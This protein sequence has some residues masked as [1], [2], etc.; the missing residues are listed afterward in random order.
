[1]LN[2]LQFI[3]W[4]ILWG[5]PLV[6]LLL[7]VG[8]FFTFK[9]NFF[10]I[11]Y[12]RHIIKEVFN[13]FFKKQNS[14]S[15]INGVISP[16][17][18]LSIA[19][20]ATVGVGNIGGVAAAI[21]IGGPGAV[22]WLWVGGIFG[23]I[24]KMVEI[25]LAVHYRTKEKNGLAYGGPTYYMKKG[26]GQEKK[27]KYTAHILSFIF[28]SS[29]LVSFFITMQN[30]TVSE[31]LSST[32]KLDMITVSCI[33]TILLYSII[34]GG[35]RS[36]GKIAAMLVPVM[37]VFYITGGL[38]IIIKNINLLP[39]AIELIISGAFTGTAAIG[40]FGGAI[41]AQVIKIG[42]SR[43]VFSNEAGWGSSSMIHASAKTDHPIRQGMLGIFEV[44]IDTIIICSIT[45]LAIIITGEWSSG[46]SGA[47]LTLNA[48]EHGFGTSGRYIMAIGILFF[49]LTTS[50]GLFVQFEVLLRYVLGE[51]NKLKNKIL[52]IYKWIYPIPGILLVVIAVTWKM[53]GSYVWLF[54]DLSTALPI[55][56]N[57]LAML[58]LSSKFFKLLND[59]K[60]RHMGIG[61]IEKSFNVFYDN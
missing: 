15:N 1:M 35:L 43:S 16:F 52:S 3:V 29:F 54:A 28:A 44:F 33:Y 58:M 32:F 49:G 10:Q 37:C 18:A 47:A 41:F 4:N 51:K 11:K 8:I 50:S 31:A 59:Y 6:T 25:T 19:I 55:F 46:K 2:Y 61:E 5:V 60:A 36:L 45:C 26:I 39:S 9:T 23:Q 12:F 48:F 40:G 14:N 21:A 13:N 27:H 57:I 56:A 34:C 38:W 7:G 24:T 22:F 30:Y 53:P 20:G 17:Q 42:V